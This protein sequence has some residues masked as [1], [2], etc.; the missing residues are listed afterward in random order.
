V[1]NAIIII[2][3]LIILIIII[4]IIIILLLLLII[5][6]ITASG[7]QGWAVRGRLAR[8]LRGVG[9]VTAALCKT[10]PRPAE[11]SGI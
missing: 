11:H 9:P 10:Q 6:I 7:P 5:I 2:M 4:I 1:T 8:F 3:I